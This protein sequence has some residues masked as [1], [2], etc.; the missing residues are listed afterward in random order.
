MYNDESNPTLMNVTF[1]GNSVKNAGGGICNYKSNPTITNVTFSENSARFGGGI[2]NNVSNVTIRNSIL[3]GNT[4][5]YGGWQ[6]DSGWGTDIVSDSVVQGGYAGTNIITSDPLL[7]A[8]GNYGGFTQTIPLQ[9][10][11]SAID[12]GNDAVCPTTDQRGVTRPQGSHCDIGA[13]EV[14]VTAPFINSITRQ[15]PNPTS[16]QY[17]KFTVSFSES[18]TNVDVSDFSL[19]SEGVSGV[20]VTRVI[21]SGSIY[22]VTVN[23]GSNTGTIRLDVPVSATITDFDGNSLINLP[24]LSGEIYT[25]T[26]RF[27]IY[28][29]IIQR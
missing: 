2:N 9:A 21:G 22:T 28:L 1:R 29:P 26:T 12:M 8:L 11:S 23:A 5:S 10:G 3:W 16:A 14:D 25:I 18:V 6:I 13:Y 27:T 20:H 7:G 19:T 17:V 15:D 24:F 4:S